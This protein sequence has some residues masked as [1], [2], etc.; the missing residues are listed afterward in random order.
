MAADGTWR[1]IDARTVAVSWDPAPV[2]G[3]GQLS[4]ALDA[5]ESDW[6]TTGGGS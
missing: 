6:Q 2:N 4:I 1:E 5:A 3:V